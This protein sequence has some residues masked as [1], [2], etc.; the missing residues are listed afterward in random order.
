MHFT[1]ARASNR[2]YTWGMDIATN[3]RIAATA[4]LMVRRSWYASDGDGAAVVE[5]VAHGTATF[6][7]RWRSTANLHRG[8]SAARVRKFRTEGAAV[9]FAQTKEASLAAALSS[10][11]TIAA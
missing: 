5:V 1:L 2:P 9:A 8:W 11:S 7:V 6:A 10:Q 3:L 4:D